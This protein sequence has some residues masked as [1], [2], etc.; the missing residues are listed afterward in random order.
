MSFAGQESFTV[1]GELVF[2]TVPRWRRIGRQYI[3]ATEEPVIEFSNISR[4][5][6]SGVAL[7]LAWL[8]DAKERGRVIRFA[9]MPQQLVDIAQVYGVLDVLK[10]NLT[11]Q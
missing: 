5:D 10:S 3:N 7:L 11:T 9:Q 8:R 2:K 6:S 4:C 1:T